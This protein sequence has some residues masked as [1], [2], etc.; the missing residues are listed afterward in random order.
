MPGQSLDFLLVLLGDTANYR[1]LGVL[2]PIGMLG[3]VMFKLALSNAHPIIIS[4]IISNP[5]LPPW[6]RSSSRE[7]RSQSRP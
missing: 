7:C 6:W 5:S 4:A 3:L 1:K 2:F